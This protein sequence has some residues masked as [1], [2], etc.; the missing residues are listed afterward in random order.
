MLIE[1]EQLL[2][3]GKEKYV[4]FET[5]FYSPTDDIYQAIFLMHTHG[6]KPVYAHPERYMYYHQDFY[7]YK[8]LKEKGVLFQMNLVSLL[9]NYSPGSKKIAE[10][11]IDHQMIDFVGTDVHNENY[12]IG[13]KQLL[14]NKYLYK[15]LNSGKLLNPEL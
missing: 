8:E 4:L 13:I 1:T 12:L 11:L 5:S 2:C 14:Y 10:Q 15:L 7:I 9:N 3:F 6:Y